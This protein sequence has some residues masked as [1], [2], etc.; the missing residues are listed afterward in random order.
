MYLNIHNSSRPTLLGHPLITTIPFT[1]P[2]KHT[3]K[4]PSLNK[5]LNS[6]N[7]TRILSIHNHFPNLFLLSRSKLYTEILF[8]GIGF[9]RYK[10]IIWF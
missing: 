3:R 7:I 10:C 8:R 6:L 2:Q 5:L 4:L 9:S 1:L